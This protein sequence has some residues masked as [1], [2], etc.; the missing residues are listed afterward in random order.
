MTIVEYLY[1]PLYAE[2]NLI[3]AQGINDKS[4]KSGI[5]PYTGR[6]QIMIIMIKHKNKILNIDNSKLV[7]Y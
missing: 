5:L 4:L 3:Q 7:N 6:L 1:S 2:I